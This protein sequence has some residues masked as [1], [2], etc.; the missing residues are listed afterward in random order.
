VG[1]QGYV[2]V[3]GATVA[4][5]ATGEA[6][7][8]VAMRTDTL[9]PWFSCSKAL[10]AVAVAKAWETH[11][12]HLD[13]RVA[14]YVFEFGSHGKDGV[15]I[16]HLLTHTAGLRFAGETA[17]AH[18][19]HDDP[20]AAWEA[21]IERLC[22][23]E[24][25]R[26]WVPGRRAG[27]HARSTFFLLGEIVRR[28][29]GRS[30]DRY[31]REEVLEPLAMDDCWL[32]VPP[33]VHARYGDRIAVVHDTV[34]SG[35]RPPA[36]AWDLAAPEAMALCSPGSSGVGPMEQLGRLFEMLLGGGELEGCRVLAPQTVEAITAR[37]RVGMRDETFGALIDW[38]L[39][40]MVDSRHY[41]VDAYPYGY[42][43]HSSPRTFGH[44]GRQSSIAFADPEHA[45]VV[46]LAANG[47]PGERANTAR[48]HLLL[49][50]LYE[51]L[52]LAGS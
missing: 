43:S 29:D 16:R 22:R 49:T 47:R 51:E 2:S 34:P 18:G 13:D 39:G 3:A 14:D 33:P 11:R 32:A 15:T 46:A 1:A 5:F 50:I 24:L 26:G 36:P 6:R 38:G 31:A 25:E 30:F 45:L 28:L 12:F 19:T 9:V 27:Y 20:A 42:G 48:F 40:F 52:G 8:G 4:T 21:A 7:P 23:A 10:T 17:D 37:H 35:G 44:G 41:G